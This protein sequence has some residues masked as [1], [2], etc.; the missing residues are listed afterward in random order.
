MYKGS[1]PEHDDCGIDCYYSPYYKESLFRS[2][3]CYISKFLDYEKRDGTLTYIGMK[4]NK[5]YVT[6][7]YE[8]RFSEKIKPKKEYEDRYYIATNRNDVVKVS[9]RNPSDFLDRVLLKAFKPTKTP[10]KETPI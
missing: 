8:V 4:K 10:N 5:N 7:T 3:I 9:E 1:S 2:P 6:F